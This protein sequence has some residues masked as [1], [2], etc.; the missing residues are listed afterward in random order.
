MVAERRPRLRFLLQEVDLP[1]GATL[2]G[3]D[4]DCH[5]TLDD[6]LVSRRH[7]R[8]LVGSDRT[9]VED[10]GSRNGVFVNGLGVRGATPLRD[11]DRLR[12]GT[13]QLVFCEIASERHGSK[14]P[15]PFRPTGQ[16]GLCAICRQPYP[17]EMVAC[18][19][20]EGTE[21]IDEDTPVAMVVEARGASGMQLSSRAVGKDGDDRSTEDNPRVS[22]GRQ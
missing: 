7:A 22:G 2:I 17:S 6:P 15:P 18:P 12:I 13:Q 5:V 8:I 10:L 14:G 1:L 19:S 21:Q 3:R 16:L 20:C 4:A 9:V 11:G